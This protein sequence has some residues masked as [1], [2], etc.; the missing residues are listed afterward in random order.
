MSCVVIVWEFLMLLVLVEGMLKFGNGVD[1]VMRGVFV[2]IRC[3][4]SGLLLFIVIKIVVLKDF[5]VIND[6]ICLVDWEELMRV[7]S[8][9]YL[10]LER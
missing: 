10:C 4:I 3:V 1:E 7:S 8:I 6:L 5:L 2:V 9:W